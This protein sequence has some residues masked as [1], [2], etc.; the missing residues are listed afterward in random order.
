MRKQTKS[1]LTRKLD[2][3]VSQIVRGRGYCAWCKKTSGLECCHIFSRRYRS[4]RWDFD[5]LLCLCHSHHFY[6]HSNPVLFGEFVREYLGEMKYTQLKQKAQ[7][8]K[9]WTVQDL[10]DLLE[11]LKKPSPLFSAYWFSSCQVRRIETWDERK[12]YNYL[13]SD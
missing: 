5:N 2:K 9:K 10:Q 13:F 4:V 7:M 3:L 1:S 11:D 6:S 12:N 8:I